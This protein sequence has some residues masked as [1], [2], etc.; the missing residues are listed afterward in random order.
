MFVLETIPRG[1]IEE[2]VTCSA[3]PDLPRRRVGGYIDGVK[4]RLIAWILLVALGMEGPL[5]LAAIPTSMQHDCHGSTESR[6][7]TSRKPCCPSGAHMS[8][9]LDAGVL[10]LAIPMGPLSVAWHGH[11]APLPTARNASFFTRGDSPLIRPPIL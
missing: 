6:A 10:G 8:C 11:S 1:S 5:V 3:A 7:D 4:H 9:C 2:G